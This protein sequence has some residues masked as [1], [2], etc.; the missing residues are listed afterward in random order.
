MQ[1][2]E[3]VEPLLRQGERWGDLV[4]VI[5]RKLLGLNDSVARR[6][7]LI[8]LATVCEHGLKDKAAA[9]G[10]LTR[11]LEQD[12]GDGG[13]ADALERLAGEL[14]NWDRLYDVLMAR[15][16]EVADATQA[17]ELLK[18]AGQ[19]AERELPDPV[20]A[21]EAYRLAASLN[22]DADET[23]AALDRLYTQTERWDSL[24]DVI[25]RRVAANPEPAARAEL[26]LRLGELRVRAFNDGR[27]AFVAYFEVLDSDPSD[28]RAL[29]GMAAL[30][31]HP[32]LAHD[33]LDV[34]E[35]CYRDT[36]AMDKVVDLCELRAKLA[37]TDSE[38]ARLLREAARM[39]E[40]DLGQPRRALIT[41][42]RAFELDP[43]EL[44]ML[45]EIEH[46]AR[47]GR[48]WDV[49]AGLAEKTAQ[50]PVFA[51]SD[52]VSGHDK[53]TFYTRVAQWNREHL[54]DAAG[55]AAC[56]R[57]LIAIKPDA[58]DAHARL[59]E[60]LRAG[61]DQRAVLAQLRALAAVDDDGNRKS[62]TL[63]EAGRLALS[64]GEPQQASELYLQLLE[65]APDDCVAL[66]TLS[67]L[68]AAQGK[69]E[70]AVGYL[71]RWLDA[72]SDA[73]R[74]VSLHHAIAATLAGPIGDVS[75]AIAAYRRLLDEFPNEPAG[76]ASL[77][78]LYVDAARYED[79]E[80][81][82][83][84]ELETSDESERRAQLHMR[85]AG[86]Y[87]RQLNQPKR[88]FEQLRAL[89][90]ETP[91]HADAAGEFERLLAQYGSP[92]ERE[93]W[94]NE[95]AERALAGANHEVAVGCLW[96][97]AE[98][99]RGTSERYEPTLVRIH[100]LA[101]KDVRAITGLVELYR[102]DGR[103]GSAAAGLQLLIPLLP[104]AD[105]ARLALD[106]ADLAQNQLQDGTLA[107][108]ALRYALALNPDQPQTR[109]RLK[110]LL[111]DAQS[112]TTL[113]ELLEQ[114]LRRVKGAAEQAAVLREI[115][116]VRYE[117]QNDPASAV[118]YLERAVILAPDDRP[119]LLLLC[120]LYMS[121]GRAPDAI[122]VLEKLIAS[123]G[124]RRA[125]EVAVY[126]HRLAQAYEGLGQPDVA[127][128]HYDNAFR[129]DLTS[130]PVLRDL[131]RLC[132]T[133]GDLDRAQKTYRAL[134]LQKLGPEHGIT[135]S[136]VYFRLGE[137]SF[138]QGDKVKA[139]AMLER[140]I[141][142][143]G[144]H[145]QAQLLLDRL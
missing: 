96:Q 53:Q 60:L 78:A 26:L 51:S 31:E 92:Q 94:L 135:K 44:D 93:A 104:A 23:L 90:E 14:H 57:A 140:A 126:E 24:V 99:Y 81:L 88:A 142:E 66:S 79:L 62:A 17:S 105:G 42:R 6:D 114:E 55:E 22:D 38:R 69:H 16:A 130:V 113:V 41:L 80:A 20:R 83:S 5:E 21:I 101:P 139:K 49:L 61:T 129:I 7:E 108:Q 100:E 64:L 15:A 122:A 91:D 136:D 68:C 4:T 54:A 138:N 43:R 118:T 86:L 13:V 124:G 58:V 116:A 35:R 71:E 133:L 63:H 128:K 109:D 95:R 73:R 40:H 75:R 123:Y 120:D 131:G 106:L 47:V 48:A 107:E 12:A 34:L 144:Q 32:D 11:A 102:Q 70:E 30:G 19:I 125:K 111:R 117:R 46:L 143:A 85:L 141:S 76:L 8:A 103:F 18:R 10:A 33:V 56:L 127:L 27:G 115:A 87:E 77:E 98:L 89:L 2:I 39:W 52:G 9:F 28:A 25:E 97:L 112:Y 84:T 121:A 1:A 65:H 137:I 72:Q 74:R 119:A 134:L 45:D 37:P 50:H 67:D 3:V 29:E 59:L 36:Q 132:F 145:P 110:Q 82:W